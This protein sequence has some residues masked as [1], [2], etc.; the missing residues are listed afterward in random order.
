MLEVRFSTLDGGLVRASIGIADPSSLTSGYDNYDLTLVFDP[1]EATISLPDPESPP[2]YGLSDLFQGIAFAGTNELGLGHLTISGLSLSQLNPATAVGTIVFEPATSGPFS[3]TL[4]HYRLGKGSINVLQSSGA[5]TFSSTGEVTQGETQLGGGDVTSTPD[6]TAPSIVS[7]SPDDNSEVSKQIAFIS[8]TF[9]EA[10]VP[11]SS[12]IELYYGDGVLIESIDPHDPRVVFE[13][14]TLTIDPATYFLANSTYQLVLTRDSVLDPAG[15]GISK[16]R[17][18]FTTDDTGATDSDPPLLSSSSPPNG[19]NNLFPGD[20]LV[21]HFSEPVTL[22]DGFIELLTAN[23]GLVETF[24]DGSSNL[25]IDGE[26]LTINPSQDLETETDYRLIFSGNIIEDLS[27]NGYTNA[28]FEFTTAAVNRG[29]LEIITDHNEA[30]EGDLITFTLKNNSDIDLSD[31]SYRISGIQQR[32][33]TTGDMSG[34][35]S[36]PSG[37]DG[38]LTYRVAQDQAYEGEETFKLIVEGQETTVVVQDTSSASAIPQSIRASAYG[39]TVKL[40]AGPDVLRGSIGTDIAMINADSEDFQIVI[41]DDQV[42][43]TETGTL[44]IDSLS[45]VEVI[46]FRDKFVALEVDEAPGDV[47]RLYKAA[48]GREPDLNG[49]GYWISQM[50]TE[51]LPLLEVAERFVD[52]SEF[53]EIYGENPSDPEFLV[54]LYVNVLGREPDSIGY[55]W[56]LEELATNPYLSEAQMLLNFSES[57]ENH[58]A[59]EELIAQGVD[60]F[61]WLG[62]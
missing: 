38:K 30:A 61:P 23:G 14:N 57:E 20:D 2:D 60:F 6:E 43:V 21:F 26:S 49:I 5:T 55:S 51:G 44:N 3:V 31:L 41:N 16:K 10:V 4:D 7:S 32:D 33:L 53:R 58:V 22:G 8:V 52:S 1:A 12:A 17:I 24:T 40:S 39:G 45:N 27:G 29:D 13:G 19:S 48:F 18:D 28:D 59:T 47:F 62:I 54:T 35:I 36:I 37:K 56:W 9:D 46:Q 50:E 15:N 25:S 11:G 42:T 34:F